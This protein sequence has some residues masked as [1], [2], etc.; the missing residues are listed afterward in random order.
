MC[1]VI[2]LIFC[3]A[4]NFIFLI[5]EMR[6]IFMA[7]YQRLNSNIISLLYFI[8]SFSHHYRYVELSSNLFIV[9]S[10]FELSCKAFNNIAN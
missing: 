10:G 2:E 7:M 8:V 5:V 6:I 9:V 3:I 4:V 1:F